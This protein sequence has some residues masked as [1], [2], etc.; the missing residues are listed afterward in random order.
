MKEKK[1]SQMDDNMNIDMESLRLNNPFV[2][3]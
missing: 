1:E 3:K 2:K